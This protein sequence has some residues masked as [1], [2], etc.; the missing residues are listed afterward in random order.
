MLKL[1]KINGKIVADFTD[2]EVEAENAEE[3]QRYC[4]IVAGNFSDWEDF[5]IEEIIDEE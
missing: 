2:F 3:A 4:E 1:F 5:E